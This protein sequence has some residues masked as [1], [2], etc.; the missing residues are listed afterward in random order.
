MSPSP[1][2][3]ALVRFNEEG[4][5]RRARIRKLRRLY[6]ECDDRIGE[7]SGLTGF[8]ETEGSRTEFCESDREAMVAQ[9][10]F[11]MEAYRQEWERLEQDDLDAWGAFY[12]AYP[13]LALSLIEPGKPWGDIRRTGKIPMDR[14]DKN[15]L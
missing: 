13:M 10:S 9:L 3:L 12:Q 11:Q 8:A 5:R 14:G 2:T 6:A 15:A 4:A 7:I 1:A